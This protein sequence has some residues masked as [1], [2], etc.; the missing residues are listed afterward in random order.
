MCRFQSSQSQKADEDAARAAGRQ[1]GSAA[2]R[3]R[4]ARVPRPPRAVLR[5]PLHDALGAAAA[6]VRAE[7]AAAAAVAKANT[8]DDHHEVD[9]DDEVVWRTY[10]ASTFLQKLNPQMVP[11]IQKVHVPLSMAKRLLRM[12]QFVPNLQKVSFWNDVAVSSSSSTAKSKVKQITVMDIGYVSGL[13][14]VS[15]LDLSAIKT[16]HDFDAIET[17]TNV[18]TLDLSQS[19]VSD[20]ECLASLRKVKVLNLRNTRVSDLSCLAQLQTLTWLDLSDTRVQDFSPLRFLQHVEYLDL[21]RNWVQDFVPL[22]FLTALRTLKLCNSGSL[23]PLELVLN[24]P[25]L[26]A[27]HVHNT[28]LTDLFFLAGVLQLKYLDVRRTHVV[29]LSPLGLLQHLETLRID[30]SKLTSD[31]GSNDLRQEN[32]RWASGLKQ[33]KRL[34]ILQTSADIHDEQEFAYALR[35]DG[36][37]LLHFPALQSLETPALVNYDVMY[38]AMGTLRELELH[39]WTSD[40]LRQLAA[41]SKVASLKTLR[42]A[43]PASHEVVDLSPLDAFESLQSLE[44]VD[45]LF[46]DLSPLASLGH[47]EKLDLSLKSRSKRQLARKYQREQDFSFL[48]ALVKLQS[49]TLNGRV[50]FKETRVLADLS[51]LKRL[52]LSGSKVTSLSP[53]AKLTELEYLNVASTPIESIEELEPLVLL[54]EIWIPERVDCSF[55][56]ENETF[57][58]LR[59]VWH[60]DEFNCLWNNHKAPFEGKKAEIIL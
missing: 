11:F 55:L 51:Q 56:H 54:Q 41:D 16:V 30:D 6:G 4:V 49:L 20:I 43:L 14:S 24:A 60:R 47:L 21:S 19:D 39:H 22:R 31:F 32:A 33:L 38:P 10:Y 36:S 7:R 42:L 52:S 34:E 12:L 1:G 46:E 28:M 18:Q 5:Q 26:E 25:N 37:I 9:G 45:V 59:A 23:G 3:G 8:D 58:H 48:E 50:D 53:I 13:A 29:D 17:M 44:L 15:V 2:A 35:V 57:P 27:C 40:D